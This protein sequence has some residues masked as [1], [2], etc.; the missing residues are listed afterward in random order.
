[1]VEA[2]RDLF[3]ARGY[4]ATT[5]E[6][7][8]AAADVP[9]ATVYRLFGGKHGIL[10]EVLDV[11]AV[12]DDEPVAL[13]DRPEARALRD[14]PDPRRFLA[15]FA[16][17]A[18]GVLDRTGALQQVVRTAAAVDPDAADIA[19]KIDRERAAGQANVARGLAARNALRDDM[20][21]DEALDVIYTLMS[22]QIHHMLVTERGWAPDQYEQWLTRTLCATLLRDTG[23]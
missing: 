6:A 10:S 2:A 11:L 20:S 12:G 22:P 23:K 13:H 4:P 5:V 19:A 8:S 7:I 14:E 18:R 21:Q 1:M 17:I 9:Q 3:L 16:H 15:G